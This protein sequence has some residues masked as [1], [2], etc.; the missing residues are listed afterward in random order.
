MEEGM[1]KDLNVS[2]LILG[3]MFEHVG[4]AAMEYEEFVPRST[5]GRDELVV[6]TGPIHGGPFVSFRVL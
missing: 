2:C 6:S 4:A 1:G 5:L 3:A